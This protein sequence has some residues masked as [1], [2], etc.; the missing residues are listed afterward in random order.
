MIAPGVRSNKMFDDAQSL[1]E[2]R[3]TSVHATEALLCNLREQKIKHTLLVGLTAR[4]PGVS[5]AHPPP[6][7]RQRAPP[8][9]LCA[10]GGGAVVVHSG[11]LGGRMRR[12]PDGCISARPP[13]EGNVHIIGSRLHL[14]CMNDVYS[15]LSK[16]M[17][18]FCAVPQYLSIRSHGVAQ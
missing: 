16:K 9:P 14:L 2:Q 3:G 1:A 11:Q 10:R 8:P 6:E 7:L 12:G 13:W 15:A 17:L 5:S 18:C 4:A